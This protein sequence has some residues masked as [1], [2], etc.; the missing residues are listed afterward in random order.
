MAYSF[1]RTD[2]TWFRGQCVLKRW[3]TA[4]PVTE[5]NRRDREAGMRMLA[6][7]ALW[8]QIATIANQTALL[9][10]QRTDL[11]A[12]LIGIARQA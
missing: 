6:S 7:E 11:A 5:D 3:Q 4:C 9:S 1:L 2:Q 10:Q 8:I 12:H